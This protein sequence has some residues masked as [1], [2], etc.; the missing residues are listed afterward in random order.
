MSHVA[1]IRMRK[2][3]EYK[4]HWVWGTLS[5]KWR[6]FRLLIPFPSPCC[7]GFFLSSCCT[8]EE[9][10]DNIETQRL[11]LWRDE[12]ALSWYLCFGHIVTSGNHLKRELLFM[13]KAFVIVMNVD[14]KILH[15]TYIY[16]LGRQKR[17]NLCL[18]PLWP[19]LMRACFVIMRAEY[20]IVMVTRFYGKEAIWLG[21][22]FSASVKHNEHKAGRFRGELAI[23]AKVLHSQF[24]RA[25]WLVGAHCSATNAKRYCF[26]GDAG[27]LARYK[28]KVWRYCQ[29]DTYTRGQ[30]S[31]ILQFMSL[32]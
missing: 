5:F 24:T 10:T 31:G 25:D 2:L 12:K 6:S 16:L 23:C 3:L 15:Y 26:N 22:L 19:A 21:R 29:G 8:S 13:I 27:P 7:R 4:C 18:P 20:F 9:R 17:S 32:F 1:T 30:K 11:S 28:N 14:W